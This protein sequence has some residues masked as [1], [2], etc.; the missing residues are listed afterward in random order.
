VLN[1]L[2][3]D[4]RGWWTGNA[5]IEEQ[6][7]KD[8]ASLRNEIKMLLLGAG[9]SGK[10][11][12][13]KQ[14]RLIYNK[15]VYLSP[16]HDVFNH[17]ALSFSHVPLELYWHVGHTMLKRETAIER[18]STPT[19]S[20]QWGMLWSLVSAQQLI[21]R[22]LLEGVSL[23]EI[24]VSPDNQP[25]WDIIMSAPVQIEGDQM[26]PKLAEAVKELWADQGVRQ[27]FNRRNELQLNDS[28][29]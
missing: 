12:V 26:P 14:M 22:V 19:L 15:Y 20:S 10:S 1:L 5:E 29:P 25:R 17:F 24:S 6:L 13:L 7:K 21:T 11:T 8:R 9:E 4:Q 23:M 16:L 28:A 3:T 2:Y 27:A 18:L